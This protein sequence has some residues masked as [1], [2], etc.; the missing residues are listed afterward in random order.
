MPARPK[1]TGTRGVNTI[2][3]GFSEWPRVTYRASMMAK[4]YITGF[5]DGLGLHKDLL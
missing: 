4:R 1:K 2:I 5:S 3:T